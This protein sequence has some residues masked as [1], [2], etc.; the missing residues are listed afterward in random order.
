[1]NEGLRAHPEI[2]CCGLE[3]GLCP[4]YYTDGSSRCPGCG[5]AEFEQKH[6]SCGFV[7]CCVKKHSLEFC[8]QCGSFPCAKF[9]NETGEKDSFVTH[10]NVAKN[11]SWIAEGGLDSLLAEQSARRGVLEKLLG[12][13][14]EGRSKSFYCTACALLPLE[15]LTSALEGMNGYTGNEPTKEM[16]A[17]LESAGFILNI[18]LK[19]RH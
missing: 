2:G 16:R 8:G 17:R 5:G 11:S 9:A 7:T 6:P 3:C 15:I 12:A 1:M 14:D 4:R 19:L 18:E 13:Y 10:R